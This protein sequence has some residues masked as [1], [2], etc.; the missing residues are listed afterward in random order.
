MSTTKTNLLWKSFKGIRKLNTINSDTELG[1]DNMLNV[2]LSKE[3][4][5]QNRSIRSSGWFNAFMEADEPVIQL[6]SA[7]LSGYA[8]TNQLIAFTKTVGHINAYIIQD[9]RGIII[10]DKIAEFPLAADVTDICMTQFGDR[11]VMA[12][13]FGTNNLGFVTYSVTSLSDSGWTQ[14]PDTSWWYRT[15]AIT[16]SSTS[17]SVTN[18]T[19]IRPYRSRLAITGRT[20]YT[21]DS[22]EAIYGIWFSEAGNPINFDHDY[23][24]SATDTGAFFVEV[25]EPITKLVEYHGLTGFGMNRSYNIYGT[26][27]SD[28]TVNPLTAKG[29]K[30]N[31]VF[32]LNGQCVYVDSF[33]TNIFSMRDNIDNTIGFDA[34]LGDDI[35]DYLQDVDDVTINAIGRRVRMMKKQVNL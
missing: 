28:I 9:D 2:S 10:Q 4:S 21:E 5:G 13:A 35:Q 20:T 18:I 16:E 29:V 34:P 19:S 32:V 22:V 14:M 27:A 17:A 30:N 23:S 25:G 24:E 31:A 3:K 8:Y 12:V 6:F 7:N 11:L 26:T 1:A 15:N 33:S